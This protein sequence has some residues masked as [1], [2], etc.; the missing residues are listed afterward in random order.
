[1]EDQ[2]LHLPVNLR[3]RNRPIPAALAADA[4]LWSNPEW[5]LW[6]RK[7]HVT[8]RPRSEPNPTPSPAAPSREPSPSPSEAS[9]GRQSPAPRRRRIN[10]IAIGGWTAER[11]DPL[12][13]PTPQEEESTP[14]Y[15]SP[16][17]PPQEEKIPE[18]PQDTPAAGT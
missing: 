3:R 17:Q 6:Q 16:L 10:R 7:H 4:P 5:W 1:V 9:S 11:P 12:P 18:I 15:P 8:R 14:K 13:S 2:L